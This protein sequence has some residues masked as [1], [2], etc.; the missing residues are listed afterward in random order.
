MER[1]WKILLLISVGSF[2]AFLDAPIVSIAFPAIAEDFPNSSATSLAWVLD[3]YFIAFAAVPVFAGKIADRYG[4][5]RL[6]LGA[7]VAFTAVSVVAGAAPSTEVLIAARVGQGIAAGFMYPA[8]QSL[9]LAAFPA[10]KRKMAL[11][12]LA[13]VVGLAIAISP[14]LGGFVVDGPGWRWIFYLNVLLGGAALIYGMRLLSP[15][16]LRIARPGTAFPDAVGALLQGG[17]V[18]L[19]VLLILRYESWG[20]TSTQSIVALAAALIAVPLFIQRCRSHPAPVL[21]LEL[22]RDRTFATANVA[23]MLLGVM[24]YGVIIN[25]VFFQTTVWGYSLIESGLTFIPGALI[26]AVVGGPAGSIAEKR[27]PRVVAVVGSVVAFAGIVYWIV[28]TTDEPNYI[29]AWLPAQLLWSAGATAAI[30]AL[31]GGALTAAPQEH[32]ANASGINLTFRQIGGAV[33]VAIA[34][35]VTA[36]GA[37]TI[38]DRS[39][40]VFVVMAVATA[41]GGIVATALARP[42]PTAGDATGPAPDEASPAAPVTSA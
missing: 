3:G 1:H 22:F 16:E 29:G 11:G 42:A 30:T 26:G 7:I 40:D 19:L 24:F 6:F 13:A 35:A 18:A 8:G 38:L 27:G 14:T 5:G 15:E 36:H 20:L 39:H 12:V 34:V 41:L 25:A 4:R 32:Y 37:G 33:G 31:L 17:A 9:L 28:A 23:S 2:T 21:D 10:E